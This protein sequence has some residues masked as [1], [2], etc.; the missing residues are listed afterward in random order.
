MPRAARRAVLGG[1]AVLALWLVVAVALVFLAYGD[2][3][4]GVRAV[5]GAQGAL[6]PELA[7]SG[8]LQRDLL[9]ARRSF[10][11]AAARSGGPL[12][13]PL[14]LLPV[15]G[16]QVRSFHA[17]S[18]AAA[19]ITRAGAD[20]ARRAEAALRSAP[21]A[22]GRVGAI[23]VLARESDALERRLARVELGPADALVGP[24]RRRRDELARHLADARRTLQRG[25]DVLVA[26]RDVLEGPQT[27]LVLAAN[28]A[29]MRAGSGMFLSA[30]ALETVNGALRLG[31]MQPTGDLA[32]PGDG[33]PAPGDL[34]ARWGFLHP[35]REW[36]NLGT[37][38]RF[39]A[40]ASLAADMWQARTGQKV[41]GVLALDPV[42]VRAILR[43]VGPVDVAG[44]A[45]TAER[46][47]PYL[48]HDQYVGLD[49]TDA[50][51]ARREQLGAL[52]EAALARLDQ[53]EFDLRRLVAGFMEA[54][55]GRHVLA[56][57]A[58][59]ADQDAW[60]AAGVDGGLTDRSVLVA[61]LNRGGNK[62]DQYVA[63]S[64]RLVWRPRAE[65]TEGTLTISLRNSAPDSEGSYLLGP[66]PGTGLAVG[67]YQGIVAVTL[68][69]A[70]TKVEIE[71]A[72]PLVAAGPDGPAAVV[73]APVLLR[74]G[75]SLELVVRFVLPLDVDRV[76]VEPSAR[77]APSVWRIGTERFMDD[78]GTWFSVPRA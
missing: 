46:V 74:R 8:D 55:R 15:V 66:Y 51:A 23:D 61:V 11:D 73:A 45:I 3:R 10:D 77:I 41:D 13:L 33:L 44:T 14:R 32:L 2:A 30:G 50:Q 65:G 78:H 40:S 29:E 16:R 36:R 9:H 7:G 47:V 60:E 71:G 28:N 31:P 75:A 34:G 4:R 37:S 54:A 12:T 25:G 22:Q 27:Y 49:A 42:A 6:S 38:P 39:D 48:L 35:G 76:F 59:E 64:N 19:E 20:A 70:A 43:V 17:L 5:G 52:A 21:G 62:L 1:V 53:G 18:N 69:G 24:L 58:H 63:A 67:D 68:P 57:S 72:G 56:W 26:V